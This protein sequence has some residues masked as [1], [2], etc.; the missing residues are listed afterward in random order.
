MHLPK[1]TKQDS[2]HGLRA[3]ALVWLVGSALACATPPQTPTA[4][5]ATASLRH[6]AAGSVIDSNSTPMSR[7]TKI[8]A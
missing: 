4:E 5:T 2:P 3:F 7:N 1:T 6:P 8:T